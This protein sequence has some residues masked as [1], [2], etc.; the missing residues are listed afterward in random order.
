MTKKK[1][2]SILM[3][4]ILVIYIVP[5]A[6]SAQEAPKSVKITDCG[7]FDVDWSETAEVFSVGWDYSDINLDDVTAVRVGEKDANGRTIMEYTADE[8]QIAWQRDNSYIT[9][10]GASSVPFYKDYEGTPIAEERDND[11]TATKGEGFEVWQPTLFYVEVKTAED[12]YYD[13]VGYQYDYPTVEV[14][15]CGHFDVDWSETADVFSV[16]W[17]YGDINLD[18]VTAVRVGAKDANGRTVMEYTADEAQI[19]WQRDNS[20]IT[21]EGLSSVPFYKDYEGTPIAEGRDDDWTATKGEGFDLWQPTLFYVEVKTANATYYDEMGYQYDYPTVEITD[22]GHF[23]EV[24]WAGEAGAYSVG[25]KYSNFNMN[26]IV[27]IRV[28]MKDAKDRTVMEYTA[29]EAQIAWQ[30]ANGYITA[31][32]LTSASFYK[33]YNGTPVAE[34]RDDDWTVTKGEGFDLWQPTLFYVEAK[35][36]GTTH[37]DEMTYSYD[38]P[39]VHELTH[40]GANDATCTK[41]GNI[42]YWYCADCGKYFSDE[43]C[44][45][46]ITLE[47]TII[48]A[49]GHGE[50]EV[51]NVKDATCTE[52]GYTGDTVCKDCG[53]VLEQG[54]TIPK[55]AHSYKDGKCTVC[56]AAD[57]DY[58]PADS[59][60]N[61]T[62]SPLTGNSSNLGLW[63]VLLLVSAS[64]LTGATLFVRKRNTR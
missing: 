30:K 55:L 4:V 6:V 3:T 28:G 57:P 35:T 7:H 31:N 37:Y 59:E 43:A 38:Y 46:E 36:A 41:D 60:N 34:G 61:G 1:W 39:H 64:G 54:K 8:A 49:T 53:A 33:E 18:D 16:G 14:T 45:T 24:T 22:C 25:W 11:W 26:D 47:D 21:A 51:V 62:D 63:I 2:L 9:A 29:D 52:E 42:E 32:G 27:S 58:K 10:D 20:Y 56:G 40:F 13:E 12:T 44:E 17:N 15:D 48:K 19:A 23:N 50:T 5:M